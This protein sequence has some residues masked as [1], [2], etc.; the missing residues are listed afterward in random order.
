MC[1]YMFVRAYIYENA[2]TKTTTIIAKKKKYNNLLEINTNY[3]N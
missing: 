1:A 3:L 2:T